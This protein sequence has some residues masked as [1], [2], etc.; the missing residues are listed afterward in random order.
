MSVR[1]S[2]PDGSYA[3]F[4][5]VNGELYSLFVPDWDYTIDVSDW[6][7]KPTFA[8][9]SWVKSEFSS[10]AEDTECK[11]RGSPNSILSMS[12]NSKYAQ[13]SIASTNNCFP[14]RVGT[15]AV[16][17]TYSFQPVA[18]PAKVSSPTGYVYDAMLSPVLK[19]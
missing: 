13:F 12:G 1:R 16:A 2:I 9:M 3:V 11:V 6:C 18:G 10:I 4:A 17:S 5:S 7:G 14:D 15:G 8:R 19:S